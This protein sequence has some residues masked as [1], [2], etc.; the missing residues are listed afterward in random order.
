M[1]TMISCACGHVGA[2]GDGPLPRELV[3]S[4]CGSS[5][6]IGA[7]HGKP[8]VSGERFEEW[9]SSER[10]RPQVRRKATVSLQERRW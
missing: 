6:L 5:Q 3:C 8:I 4:R 2:M 7:G 10:P 1:M 9:L